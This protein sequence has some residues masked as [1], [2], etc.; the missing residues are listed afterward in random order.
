MKF[1]K[2]PRAYLDQLALN[3]SLVAELPL[4]IKQ[5]VWEVSPEVFRNYIR[6]VAEQYASESDRWN[7][8]SK[9][10]AKASDITEYFESVAAAQQGTVVRF[11]NRREGDQLLRALV[12][13][14]GNSEQ[15][16]DVA[17]ATLRDLFSQSQNF[18]YAVLRL[19]LLMSLHDETKREVNFL[20][21]SLSLTML[22]T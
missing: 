9:L 7:L 18:M 19:E 16:Y 6:K 20:L 11:R 15:L 13:S 17:A 1:P 2:I 3:P 10:S 22:S 12:E 5:Q 4:K 21:F 8:Y 14:I